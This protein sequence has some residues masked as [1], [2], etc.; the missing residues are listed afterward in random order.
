MRPYLSPHTPVPTPAPHLEH[1]L[2][3]SSRNT[4]ASLTRVQLLGGRTE[5]GILR[6]SVSDIWTLGRSPRG[7]EA[8]CLGYAIRQVVKIEDLQEICRLS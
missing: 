3:P 4:H 5:L 6:D 1:R 2:R 8:C 7:T